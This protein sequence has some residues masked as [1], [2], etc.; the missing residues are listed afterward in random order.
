MAPSPLRCHSPFGLQLD[1]GTQTHA[2]CLP[3]RIKKGLSLAWLRKVDSR[4]SK[5]EHEGLAFFMAGLLMPP[6]SCNAGC[7]GTASPGQAGG[8]SHTD[9]VWEGCEMGVSIRLV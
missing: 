6:R 4:D 2:H 7:S 3:R 8:V 1:K 5:Q 9:L